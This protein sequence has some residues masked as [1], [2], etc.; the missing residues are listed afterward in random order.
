VRRGMKRRLL[1]WTR[2]CLTPAWSTRGVAP[3]KG[4]RFARTAAQHDFDQT[5]I[6]STP[7]L[8]RNESR[9]SP[10]VHRHATAGRRIRAGRQRP[11]NPR[12]GRGLDRNRVAT[13]PSRGDTIRAARVIHTQDLPPAPRPIQSWSM[14]PNAPRRTDKLRPLHH[15]ASRTVHPAIPGAIW[16]P[17]RLLWTRGTSPPHGRFF[18]PTSGYGNGQ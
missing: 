2:I 10:V 18:P 11:P 12:T 1:Y 6:A 7:R 3:Q 15:L 16:I 9:A 5:L 14:D 13:T 8:T 17:G 4:D